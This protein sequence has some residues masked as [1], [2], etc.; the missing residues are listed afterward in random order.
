MDG[1]RCFSVANVG[2]YGWKS[3]I[4]WM[5]RVQIWRYTARSCCF[6]F[7]PIMGLKSRVDCCLWHSHHCWVNPISPGCLSMTG[8]LRNIGNLSQPGINW[9]LW[10]PGLIIS[11]IFL[12][13]IPTSWLLHLRF[14]TCASQKAPLLVNGWSTD[15][16]E[17]QRFLQSAARLPYYNPCKQTGQKA[18][19]LSEPARF[20]CWKSMLPKSHRTSSDQLVMNGKITPRVSPPAIACTCSSPLTT[21]APYA[22]PHLG[23][24]AHLTLRV[25]WVWLSLTGPTN[26]GWWMLKR[27]LQSSM[28]VSLFNG[29]V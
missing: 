9:F 25:W 29:F 13:H 17:I 5:L 26:C 11:C 19:K 20:R 24:T 3:K 1:Y 23:D 6:C 22:I 7:L 18:V 28:F 21:M 2:M 4:C 12:C 27:T 14:M 16:L 8:N 15:Q 10:R